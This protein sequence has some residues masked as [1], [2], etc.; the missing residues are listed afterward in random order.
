MQTTT[1]VVS[2]VYKMLLCANTLNLWLGSTVT[3]ATVLPRLLKHYPCLTAK[4]QFHFRGYEAR[5]SRAHHWL[6]YHSVD[7]RS[8][9]PSIATSVSVH[10]MQLVSIGLWYVV[11]AS[12]LPSGG[13]FSHRRCTICF[14]YAARYVHHEQALETICLQAAVVSRH[15]PSLYMRSSRQR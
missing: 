2:T 1:N 12:F 11:Q 8:H 14:H 9:Q 5:P 6:G 3:S 7:I 10:V 13:R 4:L 15:I